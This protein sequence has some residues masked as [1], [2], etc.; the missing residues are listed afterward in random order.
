MIKEANVIVEPFNVYGNS[1]K[2]N[3]M[4]N[5]F[6][7]IYNNTPIKG[8]YMEDIIGRGFTGDVTFKLSS[9]RIDDNHD[10]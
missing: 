7:T 2:P 4:I 10:S 6:V 1:P 3:D 5:V 9:I 8:V